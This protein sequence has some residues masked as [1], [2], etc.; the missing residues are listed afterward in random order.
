ME[1]VKDMFK[2]ATDKAYL[3]QPNVELNNTTIGDAIKY[4]TSFVEEVD[5]LRAL[6][7]HQIAVFGQEDS[8]A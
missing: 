7:A 6:H 3:T 8:N 1:N 5:L 2:N 4:K